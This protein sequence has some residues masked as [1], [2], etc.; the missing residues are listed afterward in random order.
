MAHIIVIEDNVQSSRMVAKLLRKAGH[1][2]VVSDTGE[3]GLLAVF[4]SVPD[5]VLMDLGLPDIDGQ[6]VIGVIRQQPTLATMPI[7]AFTAWPEDTAYSMA[8]AYNC[9]GVITK[10]IDTRML[11]AQV[12]KFIATAQIMKSNSPKDNSIPG[13]TSAIEDVKE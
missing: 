10:P 6:T 1:T 3:G 13:K 8:A 9:D 2:V 7:I 4:E 11:V 5:L 12:E